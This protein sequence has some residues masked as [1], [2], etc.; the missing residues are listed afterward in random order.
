MNAP[1]CSVTD[2]ARACGGHCGCA[3]ETPAAA[4]PVPSL[5]PGAHPASEGEW[6]PTLR[7][8]EDLELADAR[9]WTLYGIVAALL[10]IALAVGLALQDAEISAYLVGFGGLGAIVAGLWKTSQQERERDAAARQIFATTSPALLAR[11]TVSQAYSERTR[12]AIVNFLNRQYPGWGVD[13]ASADAAWADLR[14]ARGGRSCGTG[15][16]GGCR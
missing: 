3:A 14:N 4:A 5:T 7:N 11:A 16:G 8:V 12:V 13:L 6:L 15:C 9:P 2:S 1:D 10:L